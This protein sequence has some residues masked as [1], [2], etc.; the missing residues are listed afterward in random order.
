M[1]GYKDESNQY[2]DAL[3]HTYCFTRY[4]HDDQVHPSESRAMMSVY[5]CDEEDWAMVVM[6]C[7]REKQHGVKLYSER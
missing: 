5:V 4:V 3:F 7:H 6:N 2:T 1:C